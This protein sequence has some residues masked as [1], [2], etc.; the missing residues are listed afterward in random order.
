[1]ETNVT[2]SKEEIG[3]LELF[4]FVKRDGG[5]SSFLS[6]AGLS[7]NC[8]LLNFKEETE[9]EPEISQSKCQSVSLKNLGTEIVTNH[10]KTSN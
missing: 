1:M 5:K 10:Y 6:N 3:Q 9:K 4:Q 7:K 2:S 8:Q